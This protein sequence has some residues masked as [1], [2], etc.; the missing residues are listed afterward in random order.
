MEPSC[1]LIEKKAQ[2]MNKKV[3][4]VETLVDGAIKVLLEEDDWVKHNRLVKEK[5]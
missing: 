2:E 4:I 3:E 1:R 5:M